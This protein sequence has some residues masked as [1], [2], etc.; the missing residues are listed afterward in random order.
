MD[1]DF[2]PGTSHLID[3]ILRIRRIRSDLFGAGLF[4]DPAWDILLQLY[5]AKSRG[6]RLG[7]ADIESD[8]PRSTLARW[9]SVLEERGF[10]TCRIDPAEPAMLRLALSASGELR[11]SGLLATLHPSDP[12]A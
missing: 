9:A 2:A 10:I 6:G 12:V 3:G 5:A 1:A 4:S 7:L 8:V 11:M